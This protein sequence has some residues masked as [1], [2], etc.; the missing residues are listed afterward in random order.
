MLTGLFM[1][2]GIP[3]SVYYGSDD[4]TALIISFVVTFLAGSILWLITRKN[5]NKEIKKRDGYLVVA[6]SWI[7]VS[8]FGALPYI[9]YGAVPTFIDAFFE[10]VSGLTTTGATILRDIEA[11]PYGL[12]FWRSMTHWLGGMGVVVLTLAILPILGIGGMQLYSAEIAGPTKD[13]IHPRVRETAKRLWVI[14][15]FFTLLESVLLFIG[16]MNVFDSLCHSF[17]TLATGGFSTKNTSI[18]HFNSPYIEYIILIFMFIAGTNFSLHYFA[19]H[20]RIKSYWRDDEFRF[21][22]RFLAVLILITALFLIIFTGQSGERGFRN[23]AFSLISI[24]TTTGYATEN[25][26]A[27]APFFSTI[28][29]FL[30]LFGACAGSTTGG[31][32]MIRHYIL[33]KNSMYEFRRLLHPNA[34]IPVKYNNKSVNPEIISKISA[35]VLIYVIIWII[36][37]FA[38]AITGMDLTDAVSASAACIG[39]IGPGLGIVGP[40]GNYADINA[41]GK[42]LLSG[43]MILGRLELFTIL[44]ILTPYFWKK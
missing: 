29:L 42:L 23:A 17:G 22:V 28:F 24:I 6:L 33:L 19:L 18:A 26:E 14:Y 5:E 39:N 44:V 41:F 35:F 13:K 34:V 3:F 1:L 16:G 8:L 12:L 27:W 2:A 31:I 7:S 11:V 36:G 40:V 30:L 37:A 32:K 38:L 21:Y 10:S 25:Y 43:F 15:T 20:G 9:I 4:I